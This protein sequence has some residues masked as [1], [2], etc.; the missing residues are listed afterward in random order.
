VTTPA[1]APP[2]NLLT[3]DEVASMLK[4]SVRTI[5]R[6][7]DSGQLSVVRIPGLRA[8]RIR[9][10]AIDALI[11]GGAEGAACGAPHSAGRD[12]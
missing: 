2:V 4:L 6:M 9:P 7:T 3:V 8:V 5:R 10:E 12:I 11:R 1:E